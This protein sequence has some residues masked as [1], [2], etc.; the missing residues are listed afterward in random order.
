MK[1]VLRKH[2]KTGAVTIGLVLAVVFLV[3]PDPIP[4]ALYVFIAQP[5]FLVVLV[6]YI[7]SVLR[8]L[9]RKEVL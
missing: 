2:W 1:S 3:N 7:W 9:K 6:G 8:D 5:L 4:M